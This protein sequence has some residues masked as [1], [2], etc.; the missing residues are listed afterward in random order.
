M[1]VHFRNWRRLP[2]HIVFFSVVQTGS[3]W[4]KEEER[5]HVT[6]FAEGEHGTVV[7][8][9][10]HYGY[11]EQPN[12]REA[13]RTLKERGR[14]RIPQQAGRWLILIGLERFI[15]PGRNVLERLRIGIFS[16][17]NRLAKPVT[18]Y[19][20]LETDAAVVMESINV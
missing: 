14:I 16:R 3:P 10:A 15:T 9:Q 8:V 17:L 18:D 20:G 19:F 6:A 11:M 12:V 1:A 2:R 7:S 13:L 4:V 5:C